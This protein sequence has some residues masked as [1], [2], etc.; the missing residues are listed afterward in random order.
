MPNGQIRY[1]HKQ[2]GGSKTTGIIIRTLSWKWVD[3]D[4]KEHKLLIAKYLYVKR[5][6]LRLLSPRHCTQTKKYLKRTQ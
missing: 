3:N 6:N 1:N 5:G 4:R 2:I